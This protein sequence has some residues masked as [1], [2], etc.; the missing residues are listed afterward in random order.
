MQLRNVKIEMEHYI[1]FVLNGQ[2]WFYVGGSGAE[3]K[4]W[5]VKKADAKIFKDIS[6]ATDTLQKVASNGATI[7]LKIG[8]KSHR[9]SR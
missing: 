7:S 3:E 2:D 5:S 1:K 6:K 4:D 8:A 9:R